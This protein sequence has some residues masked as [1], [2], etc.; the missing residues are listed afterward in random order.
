MPVLHKGLERIKAPDALGIRT[1]NDA[2]IL[3]VVGGDGPAHLLGELFGLF[4]RVDG[5]H[6]LRRVL[7]GRIF[8]INLSLGEHGGDRGGLRDEVDELLLD[9]VADHA[10][11]LCAENVERV[12]RNFLVRI[13]LKRDEADLRAVAVRDHEFVAFIGLGDLFASDA[14]VGLL[15]VAAHGFAAFLKGVAAESDD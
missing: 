5:A 9:Q 1:R 12:H 7:E 14:H 8:G 2:A 4:L 11:G 6:G 15:D 3:V 10:D 13:V